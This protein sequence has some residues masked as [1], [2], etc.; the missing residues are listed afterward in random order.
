MTMLDEIRA[1]RTEILAIAERCGFCLAVIPA[2]AG[3][4][5]LYPKT[6]AFAG[7]TAVG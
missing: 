3:I 2:K 1:K 5:S 7:V 6:P 4:W